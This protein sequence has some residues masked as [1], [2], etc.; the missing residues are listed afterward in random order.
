MFMF[1]TRIFLH[2]FIH[3]ILTN[4][5]VLP[6]GINFIEI[7]HD[8]THRKKSIKPRQDPFF[9]NDLKIQSIR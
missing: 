4:A 3:F 2:E 7:L 1:S 5:S 9:P 8:Y 6:N